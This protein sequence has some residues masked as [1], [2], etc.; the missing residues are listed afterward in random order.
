MPNLL[1]KKARAEMI[2][3]N[4]AAPARPGGTVVLVAVAVVQAVQGKGGGQKVRAHV[5]P[6]EMAKVRGRG[7]RFMSAAI[8]AIRASGANRRNHCLKLVP[9][10]FQMKGESNPWPARS[11]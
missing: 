5:V 9:P 1:V 10:S 11:K 4:A 7:A 2:G 6:G 8:F 3:A